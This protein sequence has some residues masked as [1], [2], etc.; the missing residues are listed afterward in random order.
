MINNNPLLIINKILGMAYLVTILTYLA[1]YVTS[2]RWYLSG[3]I[4]RH[5]LFESRS[6]IK[7]KRSLCPYVLHN[8][9]LPLSFSKTIPVIT[10][11]VAD[12]MVTVIHNFYEKFQH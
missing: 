7:K 1:L 2:P 10:V 9:L 11:I 8:F 3:M 5:V 4:I 6:N 12:T